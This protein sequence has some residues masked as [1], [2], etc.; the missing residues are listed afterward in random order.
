MERYNSR[1]RT[2]EGQSHNVSMKIVAPALDE[3][4]SGEALIR[5]EVSTWTSRALS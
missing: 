2:L 5:P 4:F 1:R 3:F